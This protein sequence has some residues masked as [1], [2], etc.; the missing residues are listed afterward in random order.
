MLYFVKFKD[1]MCN[2]CAFSP[3]FYFSVSF[4]P[5]WMKI[6][7]KFRE[8]VGLHTYCLKL[9]LNLSWTG[10]RTAVLSGL[11]QK[12][13]E[14]QDHWS[15]WTGYSPVWFLVSF[16]SYKPDLEALE[17]CKTLSCCDVVHRSAGQ[18]NSPF[19][20]SIHFQQRGI[21]IKQS[22]HCHV[23][24]CS[25]SQCRQILSDIS[26]LKGIQGIINPPNILQYTRAYHK[27]CCLCNKH[28]CVV[29]ISC[30]IIYR[31]YDTTLWEIVLIMSSY[32]HLDT[33]TKNRI[34]G[35]A[36][37]TGNAAEAGRKEN[38]NPHTPQCICKNF[39]ETGSTARK[40]GSNPPTKLTDYDKREIVQTTRINRQMALGQ[41]QNQVA[42]NILTSTVWCVFD[43]KGYYRR[44]ARRVPYLIKK[45]RQACLAWAKKNKGMS[46]EDWGW[47]I[48]SDE[49]YVYLS[50]KQ[51]HIY[52]TRCADKEL[53]DKCLVPT[54]KQSSVWVVIW[55]CIV[56]GKKGPLVVL[57][58][59]RGKGS[60]MNSTRYQNQV[61]D[62]IL[63]P[64]Y[65]SSLFFWS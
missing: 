21:P 52:V 3:F 1:L 15:T 35:Y 55:G 50:D 56:E 20:F 57:E 19:H 27:T 36:Q 38:V 48:F 33:P 31:K 34:V 9:V 40:K 16:Q 62:P 28:G 42:A 39:S 45:H 22:L 10:L 2:F 13:W 32:S 11:S 6:T 23:A 43:G 61:L 8:N 17:G 54:F 53:L 5:F 51:G 65:T 58:Y 24:H 37:A 59:P 64:F 12:N 26:W 18:N 30:W 41:L 49:C 7:L 63:T 44:V 47:I 29:F 14:N 25:L 46:R 60:G 4:Y